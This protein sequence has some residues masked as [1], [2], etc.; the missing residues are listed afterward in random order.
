LTTDIFDANA[1]DWAKDDGLVPVVVQDA[2]T[3]RVLM[4]GY[5][6]KES[7]QETLASGFVVFFSRSRNRLWKKGETSGHVLRLREIRA[8]CDRDAVLILADAEGPTCHLGTQSCFA[9]SDRPSLAI[10]ADLAATIR[11][12]RN[13]PSP[14]S[15]TARLFAEGL[16]RMAQKVGEEGVE[17]AL[18]AGDK[19][20]L[21]AESADLLY[22]LLVLLEAGGVDWMNV[23]N[24]LRERANK[25]SGRK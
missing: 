15:Y 12:R 13:N 10:L 21:T 22:H 1:L 7:L 25:T 14:G 18:A 17:V 19:D 9:G 4:L 5:M 20:R 23:M 11:E 2:R 16:T 6:N 24:E 3:L 8:D